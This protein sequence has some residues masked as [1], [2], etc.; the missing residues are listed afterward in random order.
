[1][2]GLRIFSF[3]SFGAATKYLWETPPFTS[4]KYFR[5]K[6]TATE[7]YCDEDLLRQGFNATNIYCD[8]NLLRQTFTTTEKSTTNYSGLNFP[9]FGRHTFYRLLTWHTFTLRDTH[10]TSTG[11]YHDENLS[12][13]Y[14]WL[15]PTS[16]ST[17]PLLTELYKKNIS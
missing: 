14:F 8:G 5:P 12:L 15:Q 6:F 3:F 17:G 1:M 16:T 2:R 10:L 9:L 11:F 13:T 7:F 4:T